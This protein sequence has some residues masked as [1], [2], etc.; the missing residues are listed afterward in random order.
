MAGNE[1]DGVTSQ[2]CSLIT[3]KAVI[4]FHNSLK[5]P[6]A[7]RAH[8]RFDRSSRIVL[9]LNMYALNRHQK[10]NLTLKETGFLYSGMDM[11]NFRWKGE[12]LHSW[13]IQ[14]GGEHAGCCP[15]YRCMITRQDTYNGEKKRNPW[16]VLISYGWAK[17]VPGKQ[18][19]SFF[20]EQGSYKETEKV[21]MQL[22]DM[23]YRY[24]IREVADD[25]R[26]TGDFF[27]S[28][29]LPRWYREKEEADGRR[30]SR[31]EYPEDPDSPDGADETP[32]GGEEETLSEEAHPED[33]KDRGYELPKGAR[34]LP[35]T[36]NTPFTRDEDG[37]VT[38]TCT[39][40]GKDYCI[41]FDAVPPAFSDAATDG[42]P[43]D[44][45]LYARNGLI[46]CAGPAA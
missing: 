1:Y 21:Y 19:G 8:E 33:T 13:N 38:A 7:K 42:S 40:R 36:I 4:S 24:L 29:L 15:M 5:P 17:P 28:Y 27:A 25:I 26:K 22:T 44:A 45:V 11:P 43:I 35:L 2:I 23:D 37:D 9:D 6:K 14:K 46:R 31:R 3:D 10:F 16:S 39:V 34:I 41:F 30:D 20:A 32:Y 12:R 18:R